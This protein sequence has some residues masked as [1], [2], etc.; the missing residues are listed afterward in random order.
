MAKEYGNRT[1]KSSRKKL[2]GPVAISVWADECLPEALLLELEKVPSLDDVVSF[3]QGLARLIGKYRHEAQLE[4][5]KP[6]ITQEANALA[7]IS[8][9]CRELKGLL[10]NG[11]LFRGRDVMQQLA[12]RG[13][14]TMDFKRFV[15][16]LQ[17][18]ETVS[19]MAAAAA[20]KMPAADG[21]P[22]AT[23]RDRLLANIT[24]YC[25]KSKMTEVQARQFAAH[26]LRQLGVTVAD[27]DRAV[28]R[29]QKRGGQKPA[30]T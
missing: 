28:R 10:A 30:R 21:R 7:A 19:K 12:D 2:G 26:V 22:K 9:H 4:D 18:W 24:R 13:K 16:D 17:I 5:S 20:R 25:V 1:A 27:D 8:A 29:A 6:S 15:D 3:G 14:I 11:S 23:L